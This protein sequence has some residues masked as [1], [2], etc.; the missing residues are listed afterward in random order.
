MGQSMVK[1]AVALVSI[2]SAGTIT[3]CSKQPVPPGGVALI[4]IAHS[5]SQWT[6]VAVSKS[7]RIFVNFPRWSGSVPVSVGEVTPGGD[8]KPFPDEEWN[9]WKPALPPQNHF[10]CVQSVTIDSDD[11][12]WILD[13]ANPGFGG[14]VKDG[15]K[16]LKVDLRTNNIVQ[17]I[18]F[19]ESIAPP[20]SYLNDVRV[21]A[22]RGY[23]YI[24]DS[25]LGAVIIVNLA[26][27][28]S[29]RLL[30]DHPSTKSENTAIVIDGK[31]WRLP[32]GSFPQVHA[33]GIALDRTGDALYYHALSGR[34]LYRIGTRWLQDASLTARELG[35]KVEFLARTVV[36]DGMAF[37]PDGTL[38]LTALEENAIKRFTHDRSIET[39]VK[40]A[41]LA[42]PDSIAVGPDG[43]L[44]VTTSQIHR[45]PNPP[46]PYGLF[47]LLP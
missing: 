46:A 23:A 28:N 9:Q 31:E 7:G 20:A 8:V 15:P 11:Y 44:Y 32:D 13:P 45:G 21:D 43:F 18:V 17:K 38:Y 6:G 12:L 26:T 40:D 30:S 10:V 1:L 34:L 2:I 19:S 16:L 29:R 41:R 47:K 35:E 4:E 39:V 42:W 33:D 37:G 14:V 36:A 22:K 27:G 3:A 25:G 24:T 5:S